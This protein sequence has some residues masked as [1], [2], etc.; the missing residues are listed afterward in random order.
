MPATSTP[1]QPMIPVPHRGL[2][3]RR[4]A[5]IMA[6]DQR[7]VRYQPWGR[8]RS[9]RWWPHKGWVRYDVC[10]PDV[11]WL[12]NHGHLTHHKASPLSDRGYMAPTDQ[13]RGAYITRI[14]Y[15]LT[16]WLAGPYTT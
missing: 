3:G 6:A 15:N 8:G 13:G 16:R 1:A 7:R 9:Y 2:D 10:T 11:L 5:I 12:L 4:A 14:A